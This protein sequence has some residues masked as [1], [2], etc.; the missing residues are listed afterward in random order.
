[1]PSRAVVG[2]GLLLPAVLG[3]AV[4]APSLGARADASAAQRLAAQVSGAQAR[5]AAE[6]AQ[7]DSLQR[8]PASASRIDQ[9]RRDMQVASHQFGFREAVRSEQEA[10]YRMAADAGLEHQVL[11]ALPSQRSAGLSDAA[12]AVRS[13]WRLAGVTDFGLIAVRRS[14]DFHASEPV[15]SLRSYYV[16]AAQRYGIDWTYLGAINYVES[17]FGRV[18][19]PSSAGA[20]GPMQF[21]PSTWQAYGTGDIMSPHDSILAAARYLTVAGAPQDYR[22]AVLAYDHDG[23]YAAAVEHLSAAL[24]SDPRWL[25]RLYYWSTFG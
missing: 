4:V 19:G 13:L 7:V 16:S 12:E 9:L 17:D 14:K 6:Q 23:N 8:L 21:L 18:P 2:A 20:L 5:M 11:A 1:V 25:P 15:E 24:R 22:R 10:V 3:L